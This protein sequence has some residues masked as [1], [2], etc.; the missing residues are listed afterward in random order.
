MVQVCA[1]TVVGSAMIRGV[2]GGQKR[3][4]TSAELLVSAKQVILADEISTGL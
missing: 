3:R 1:D 2:S 4:V